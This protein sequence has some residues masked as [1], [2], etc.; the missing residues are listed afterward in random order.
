LAVYDP[1]DRRWET[2]QDQVANDLVSVPT[3]FLAS[4]MNYLRQVRLKLLAPL[5]E[6][7]SDAKKRET[8]RYLAT[9]VLADFASDQ[10][11]VLTELL[12]DADE[13]QF[14]VLYPRLRVY[15]ENASRLLVEGITKELPPE[16]PAEA[17]E[18]L[19]SRKA[20]AAVALLLLGRPEM[21]LNS[22]EH[23]PDPR[24][25]S[26]VIHRLSP[27]GVKRDTV[28]RLM[29]EQKDCC[30]RSALVLSLGEYDKKEWPEAEKNTVIEQLKRL[31]QT[32]EDPGLHGAA[33]WLLRHW[34][35]DSWLKQVEQESGKDDVQRVKRLQ[36]IGNELARGVGAA[37]PQWYVNG[38]GQTFVVIPNPG[39][40]W[41][42][43]PAGEAEREEDEQR[44]P[45][46]LNRSFA[47]STKPVTVEQFRRFRDDYP[48]DAKAS[49]HG[50]CPV[51]KTTWYAA[52]A[53]CNWLSEKE[54][55][56]KHEWCYLPNKD[57]KY[58]DGMKLAPNYL[59]RIGYRL[60]TEAEWEYA[61]RA[62]TVTS[63][64]YGETEELLK[65][66]AWYVNN[67]SRR[68]WPVGS[69]KPND[70]GLFDMH[71][72]VW[73][74]CQ[75]RY[76]ANVALPDGQVLSDSEDGLD[77]IGTELRVFRGGSFPESPAEVRA[78]C[79]IQVHPGRSTHYAGFRLARTFRKGVLK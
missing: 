27:L 41:V 69:L 16:A 74:W 72:N 42:G 31:Y 54:E 51:N 60:P 29:G 17:H 48:F 15:K 26:Y 65:K 38:Q 7:C 6:I 70:W 50:D 61:C 53:Y 47:I 14:A 57:G 3:V 12:L 28:L 44:H 18:K 73:I 36:R 39:T 55:L 8:E 37:K 21:V 68:T 75:E 9:D 63:R 11:Q 33:E 79:R 66:Y 35:Q 45:V 64:Y 5:S 20:N 43:S 52:A 23:R 30:I 13:K 77:V 58:A 34:H 40:I 56:P 4:W 25:R 67:S 59:S 46:E 22:L 71:G 49:P 76:K 2:I 62:G 24:T 19:A 10:P 1:E 32:A 78:A